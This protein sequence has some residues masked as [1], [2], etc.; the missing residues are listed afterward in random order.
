MVN[1]VFVEVR[2]MQRICH[3]FDGFIDVWSDQPIELVT[4][5][6]DSIAEKRE[7]ESLL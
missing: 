4:A 1:F 6:G 7:S 3:T 2:I 5:D